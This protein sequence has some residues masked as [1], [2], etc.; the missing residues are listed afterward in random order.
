MTYLLIANMV[1]KFKLKERKKKKKRTINKLFNVVSYHIFESG[2][3][4]AT[5]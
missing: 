3:F 1:L 4:S 5:N 2:T